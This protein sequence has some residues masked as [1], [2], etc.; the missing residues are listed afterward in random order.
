MDYHSLLVN[1]FEITG[2]VSDK[3]I[4]RRCHVLTEEK[5]NDMVRSPRKSMT[6]LAQQADVCLHSKNCYKITDTLP[7]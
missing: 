4:K 5:L 1:K 2:S 7:K 6:K 3:R